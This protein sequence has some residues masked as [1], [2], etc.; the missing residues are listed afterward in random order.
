M[1][2]VYVYQAPFSICALLYTHTQEHAHW[3]NA[4]CG[5]GSPVP[6]PPGGIA[7]SAAL[8]TSAASGDFIDGGVVC[9]RVCMFA[10]GGWEFDRA[11]MGARLSQFTHTQTRTQASYTHTNTH[12]P[13]RYVTGATMRHLRRWAFPSACSRCTQTT[14]IRIRLPDMRAMRLFTS[15]CL[16]D[17]MLGSSVPLVS[18]FLLV[19]W[20]Y[21]LSIQGCIVVDNNWMLTVLLH[22]S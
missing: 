20:P 21:L 2:C 16:N 17:D 8:S 15:V 4:V 14:I 3:M 13:K 18:F 22:A 10:C 5:G 9:E 6:V 19:M 11:I 7:T 1:A 12:T